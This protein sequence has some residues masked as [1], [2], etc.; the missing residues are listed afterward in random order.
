MNT[1]NILYYGLEYD[2][3]KE[4]YNKNFI[5]ISNE[6]IILLDEYKKIL[7][8]SNKFIDDNPESELIDTIFSIKIINPYKMPK[9]NDLYERC[10]LRLLIKESKKHPLTREQL[11]LEELDQFNMN[12]ISN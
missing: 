8:E 1:N 5:K 6:F 11:N 7:D 10:T 9:S 2:L 4:Y 3:I 12:L